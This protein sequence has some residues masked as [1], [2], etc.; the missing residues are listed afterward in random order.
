MPFYFLFYERI[1]YMKK[2]ISKNTTLKI[3]YSA[4]CLAL[5][6]VLPFLTMQIPQ[7]GKALA[8]MHIAIFLCGFLC[9]APYGAAVGFVAP[10][11][12]SFTLGM[13][14]L[15]PDAVVMAFELLAYGLLSG[16]LY[17]VL[18]K[19]I[20]YIYVSLILSMIGGRIVWG[21]VK[22]IIFGLTNTAF[23]FSAFIAGAI[24]NAVPG[25]ILHIVLVPIIIIALRK[26][27]K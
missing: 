21:I 10:L 1:F 2:T 12:R 3:T 26:H 15:F 17:R 6:M 20:P 16:L 18:P 22:F 11:L 24:T 8:P 23:P 5:A 14:L 4:I 7:F 27:I 13:P 9:G 19:K 25:I